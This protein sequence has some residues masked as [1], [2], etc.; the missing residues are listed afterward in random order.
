MDLKQLFKL[1]PSVVEWRK[2]Q[3]G[4]MQHLA[5]ELQFAQEKWA[6]TLHPQ[7]RNVIGKWH[8][9]LMHVLASEAGSLDIFFSLDTSLGLPCVGRAAHSFVMPLKILRPLCTVPALLA[10]A[11][12][13]NQKLLRSITT[14]GDVELDKASSAKTQA[15]LD[16]GVMLGPW[17]T[18]RLPAWLKVISRR[19][20]IWE[21][22]G[23]AAEKKCRNI[24]DLS[25]SGLNGSIED[26]ETYIPKGIEYIIA[27]VV[28]IR[29]IFGVGVS[30]LGWT[31]DFK[32]AYRQVAANPKEY[33]FLGIGW[34]DWQTR[35][36]LVGVLTAMA[37][38]S[39]RAPANWGRVVT[40]LCT[41]SWHHLSCSSWIML[42]TSTVWSLSFR[43]RVRARVGTACAN[44]AALCRIQ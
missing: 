17:R 39:R 5:H 9:P 22:H 8:M 30:L 42:T 16:S 13:K 19:F 1:G 36:V 3:R 33:Q 2:D 7:V 35:E 29:N 18:N 21:Q 10:A 25:E 37:F 31:A 15:E 11:A 26:Y 4:R 41:I 38:G 40:L 43:R 23:Q 14:S 27:L 6:S 32:G 34:W 44:C 20:P 12:V 28:L 24:D